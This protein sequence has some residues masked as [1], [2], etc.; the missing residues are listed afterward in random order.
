MAAASQAA[1]QFAITRSSHGC[2]TTETPDMAWHGDCL[3]SSDPFLPGRP[4]VR[5][6]KPRT[7]S[8][9]NGVQ[10]AVIARSFVMG[11]YSILALPG[12]GNGK[13]NLVA[14][15]RDMVRTDDSIGASAPHACSDM[16]NDWDPV[17]CSVISSSSSVV[18]GVSR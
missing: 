8:V 4:H 5:S 10:F 15:L 1:L 16:T 14:S 2:T 18:R 11:L 3:A 6:S 13:P 12:Y 17:T 7:N 9:S